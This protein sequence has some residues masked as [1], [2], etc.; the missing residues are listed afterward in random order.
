LASC[1]ARRGAAGCGCLR[2][3]HGRAADRA[4]WE[5]ESILV[6]VRVVAA[7][8]QRRRVNSPSL[9][10]STSAI[11]ATTAPEQPFRDDRLFVL[12][13]GAPV[14]EPLQRQPVPL[15]VF[16]LV[17]IAVAPALQVRAP[18]CFE[19]QTSRSP[20]P[21]NLPPPLQTSACKRRSGPLPVLKCAFPERLREIPDTAAQIPCYFTREF[22]R[23]LLQ[24]RRLFR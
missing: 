1:E 2:T 23:N 11:P 4:A 21:N 12:E 18:K 8:A 16:T 9:I 22:V 17:Q 14:A 15:A 24:S 10:A 7:P 6:G 5:G 13:L 19:F 3:A 20:F